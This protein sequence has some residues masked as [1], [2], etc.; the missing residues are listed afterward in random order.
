MHP[1][2]HRLACGV[3]ASLVIAVCPITAGAA[4]DVDEATQAQK[5]IDD[6][7]QQTQEKID[8][9]SDKAQQMLAEYRAARDETENLEIYNEQLARQIDSQ[10]QEIDSL[11]TQL[12]QIGRTQQEF[13]P[14]MLK[15][16]DALKKFVERDIPFQIEKRRAKVAELEE[17]MGRADV[18]TAE[19]YRQL[20]AAFQQEL[21]YGRTIN[22]YRG[23]LKLDGEQRSVR[24]LR[25]GRIALMYQTL[26]QQRTGRWNPSTDAWEPV[27]GAFRAAFE[28]GYKI[29][30]EQAPPDLLKTPVNAPGDQ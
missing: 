23:E 30:A 10:Q 27:G 12:A 9:L 20:M 25:I 28:K 19:K 2:P 17:L 21:K 18:T 29:A 14:S 11:E 22:T 13:V 8:R 15:T 5:S 3:A 6:I 16:L 24:F 7:G 4:N 26:D 1:K